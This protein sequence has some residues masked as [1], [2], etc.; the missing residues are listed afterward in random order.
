M[1]KIAFVLMV[2]FFVGCSSKNA[3]LEQLIEIISERQNEAIFEEIKVCAEVDPEVE[4]IMKIKD[5]VDDAQLKLIKLVE[6]QSDT[7]AL[8]SSM[9]FTNYIVSLVGFNP[10]LTNVLQDFLSL[11][12]YI[13][14]FMQSDKTGD[15][16]YIYM[17]KLA[18]S[19][20]GR[21][22]ADYLQTFY[23]QQNEFKS[24]SG[25]LNAALTDVLAHV[26]SKDLKAAAERLLE[27]DVQSYYLQTAKILN[28]YYD[29]IVMRSNTIA[30]AYKLY[31]TKIGEN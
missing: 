4:I 27:D 9:N 7:E 26:T 11:I 6:L 28:S 20:D 3:E 5:K 29:F 21:M 25:N 31:K 10:S 19:A 14:E 13:G 24:S 18:T 22:S 2:L 12:Q 23:D 8:S 16:E 30:E 1:R 17:K 15:S